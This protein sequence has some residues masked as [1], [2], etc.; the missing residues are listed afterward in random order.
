M[1]SDVGLILPYIGTLPVP[2]PE[3]LAATPETEIT[4]AISSL[5]ASLGNKPLAL[6]NFVHTVPSHDR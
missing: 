4:P 5:A 2:A 3:D 1:M 6:Y